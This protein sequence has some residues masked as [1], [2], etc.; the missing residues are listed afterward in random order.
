MTVYHL[1]FNRLALF[2]IH[3]SVCSAS[4]V[5][6]IQSI[7]NNKL[8]ETNPIFKTPEMIITLVATTNCNEK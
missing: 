8:C 2:I 6:E 3:F 4:S 1:P 5:A 7:K